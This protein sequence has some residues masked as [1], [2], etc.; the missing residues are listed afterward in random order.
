M[1]LITFLKVEAET[2]AKASGDV[3]DNIA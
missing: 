2:V 3:K 1:I